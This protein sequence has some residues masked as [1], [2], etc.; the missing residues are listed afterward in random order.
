MLACWVPFFSCSQLTKCCSASNTASSAQTSSSSLLPL[1]VVRGGVNNNNRGWIRSPTSLTTVASLH[2][3]DFELPAMA[4]NYNST[5]QAFTAAKIEKLEEEE[6]SR[7]N[8]MDNLSAVKEECVVVLWCVRNLFSLHC[9]C[10]RGSV[11]ACH[12]ALTDYSLSLKMRYYLLASAVVP[13]CA[14]ASYF[15]PF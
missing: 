4:K 12:T 1:M 2:Q 9:T 11:S 13:H 7:G 5:T 10:S 3:V 14:F 15:L 8:L 6:T